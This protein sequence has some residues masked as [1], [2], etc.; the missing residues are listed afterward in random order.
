MTEKEPTEGLISVVI[1]IR[2]DTTLDHSQKAEKVCFRTWKLR[3]TVHSCQMTPVPQTSV[4]L[5]RKKRPGVA[6]TARVTS[7]VLLSTQAHYPSTEH[8]ERFCLLC[9]QPRPLLTSLSARWPELPLKTPC[10]MRPWT[11]MDY[12]RSRCRVRSRRTYAP[13]IWLPLG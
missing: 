6:Q 9:F 1:L 2:T 7:E 4:G 11:G 8:T 12:Q 3:P 5:V 10:R 13:L